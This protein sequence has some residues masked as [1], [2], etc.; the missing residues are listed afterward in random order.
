MVL[1]S[2]CVCVCVANVVMRSNT[3]R[4][5]SCILFY[6]PAQKKKKAR[7][8]K[9]WRVK[10]WQKQGG[11]KRSIVLCRAVPGKE[12]PKKKST[13]SHSPRSIVSGGECSHAWQMSC[14]LFPSSPLSASWLCR[15]SKGHTPWVWDAAH[16]CHA[17][18][19]PYVRAYESV[20]VAEGRESVNRGSF[21]NGRIAGC[22]KLVRLLNT[23]PTVLSLKHTSKHRERQWERLHTYA[24]FIQ[25]K[26]STN[27]RELDSHY[28]HSISWCV[29]LC[30]FI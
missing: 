10:R 7:Q 27:T 2:M 26:T 21:S 29:C 15:H 16:R 6:F 30:V 18:R 23:S 22:Q 1:I 3:R 25:I 17:P 19:E 11:D 20:C 9:V 13:T 14:P 12:S 5:V 24:C 28:A 4:R 8:K